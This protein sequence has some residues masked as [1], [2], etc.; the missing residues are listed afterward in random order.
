M[1]VRMRMMPAGTKAVGLGLSGGG[2]GGLNLSEMGIA[3]KREVDYEALVRGYGW[4]IIG[5]GSFRFGLVVIGMEWIALS[6]YKDWLGFPMA[7]IRQ[8]Y[9]IIVSV[10][11]LTLVVFTLYCSKGVSYGASACGVIRA[12]CRLWPSSQ[13][14]RAV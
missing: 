13:S 8:A 14:N 4:V 3:G 1:Q 6:I 7:Q 2:L 5:H 10:A 11:S 9:H 12:I